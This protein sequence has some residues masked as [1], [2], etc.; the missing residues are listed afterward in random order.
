MFLWHMVMFCVYKSRMM[1]WLKLLNTVWNLFKKYVSV[2][3]DW[4]TVLAGL[5]GYRSWCP[6]RKDIIQ[7]LDI[8]CPLP[9]FCHGNHYSNIFCTKASKILQFM[10]ISY[11][12]EEMHFFRFS[13]LP[14]LHFSS[15]PLCFSLKKQ[16]EK[17]ITDI[18]A[19]K[20]DFCF[21]SVHQF[22]LLLPHSES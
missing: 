19:C 22:Q 4:W 2:N 10:T 14:F 17:K 21:V 15:P 18:F 9:V 12:R 8:L 6:E 3:S 11:L 13:F 20:D 7:V 5:N 1:K 16:T